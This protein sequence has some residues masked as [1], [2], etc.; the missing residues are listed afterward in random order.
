[1]SAGIKRKK[2]NK[3]SK[4]L[5]SKNMVENKAFNRKC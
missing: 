4:Q 1:M 3:V 2:E 5:L